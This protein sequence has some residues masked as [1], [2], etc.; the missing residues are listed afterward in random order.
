VVGVEISPDVARAAQ[1]RI[2]VNRW[3]NVQVV[4]G[5]ARVV[6]L[7]GKFDGL[8]L[9]GAPD[10]YASPEALAHLRPY[11]NDHARVVAFGS[12]LT[13]RRFG[14]PFNILVEFLMR[15]SFASTPKLNLEPWKP[16]VAYCADIQVQEYVNGCFFLAS[17][18][19]Q[20]DNH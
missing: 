17:G 4:V 13:R 12:K 15:L 18:S 2:E 8:M 6:A 7:N 14:A 16:L 11:L 10:I 9:F 20:P 3:A 5:D 1:R 19:F